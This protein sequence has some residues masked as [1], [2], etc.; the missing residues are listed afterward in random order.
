[1][2]QQLHLDV[3]LNDSHSFDNYFVARNREPVDGLVAAVTGLAAGKV[4]V[5]RV[6]FLWGESA[7]GKTHLLQATCRLAQQRGRIPFAYVP[8]TMEPALS[9]A[10]L[11]G[12]ERMALVCVDDVESICRQPSWE[13]ALF[14]LLERMRSTNGVLVLASRVNPASLDVALRDLATRLGW[15]VVYR[16]HVL[17]EAERLQALQLRARNRGLEMSEKVARYL[18]HRY[19]R[20]ARSLFDLLERIDQVSLAQQRRVT[21]PFI[22]SLE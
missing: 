21:I 19:P 6:V 8:L 16:I 4:P 1:M 2:V 13:H 3:R 14:A 17:N 22:R 5:D 15:G 12:L 10:I 7:C 9:P 20:D 11:E 18:L